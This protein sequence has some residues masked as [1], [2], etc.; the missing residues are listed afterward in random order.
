MTETSPSPGATSRGA[1]SF[2]SRARIAREG[3]SIVSRAVE[4]R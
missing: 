4:T 3:A 2:G 1:S